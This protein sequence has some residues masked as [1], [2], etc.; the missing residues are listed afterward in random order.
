VT[1]EYPLSYGQ[2]SV[3]RFIEELP[4]AR[5]AEVNLGRLLPL[6]EGVTTAATRAAVAAVCRRHESLRTTYRFDAPQGPVQVPH[7]GAEPAVTVVECGE[8]EAAARADEI[9]RAPFSLQDDLGWRAE[10]LTTRG[11]PA[12]LALAVHHLVADGWALH[13]IET[14]LSELLRNP[15]APGR[16]EPSKPSPFDP[17]PVDPTP[18]ALALEQRS[19]AWAERRA[20]ARSYWAELAAGPGSPAR[21]PARPAGARPGRIRGTL[22]LGPASGAVTE[23]ARRSRVFPQA[24]MLALFT[25]AVAARDGGGDCVIP[26]MSSNRST[27]RWQELVTSMNQQIPMRIDVDEDEE[28]GSFLRRVHE[29]GVRAYRNGCY[30]VDEMSAAS[31]RVLGPIQDLEYLF[32][33]TATGWPEPLPAAGLADLAWPDPEIS[34]SARVAAARLYALV[35]GGPSLAVDLHAGAAAHSEESLRRLLAGLAESLRAAAVDPRVPV[36]ALLSRFGA[37]MSAG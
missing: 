17:T 16:G 25:V 33:Y 23:I 15:P 35:S 19:P 6:P 37:P 20:A 24:V 30:D 32:N 34:T 5:W 7:P 8:A 1:A 26:L 11:R 9:V 3:W 2:L 4:R 14:E 29:A 13:R 22:R 27:P 10:V 31:R 36:G 21:G 18:A 12:F 28:F